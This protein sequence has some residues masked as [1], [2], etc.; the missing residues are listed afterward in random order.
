MCYRYSV[1]GPDI[2]EKRFQA[3]LE[4]KFER[5]YHAG[6]FDFPKLP[7]IT[8]EE[9]KQ[10]NLFSWGLIPFWVK[11]EKTAN[12]MRQRTANARCESIYEKPSFRQAAKN[13][14][15]LVLAD[16]F[17]EWRYY[18]GKNYPYYIYL[19][20]KEPF[21][22]AGLWDSW[23][24]KET[25]E[26]IYTY[27]IIT[28]EANPLLAKIHNKKKRMPVILRK[29]DEKKWIQND[30]DKD[31][32]MNLLIPYDEKKMDAH[33]ISKMITAKDIDP[34]TPKV[35]EPYNYK[36]LEALSSQQSLF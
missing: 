35:L 25:D 10:I 4:S 27:T 11:D 7:V 6:G 33:T 29:N 21:S 28:T 30:I 5:K 2:L 24:N 3:K 31:Q 1:P 9:P 17:F 36:D 15:C 22:I 18:R 34:N 23:K 16:G 14:H 8:N 13:K 26:T 32:A 19:K 20:N 12:E